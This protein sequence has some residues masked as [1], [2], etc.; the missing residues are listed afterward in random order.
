L[1]EV[2]V[3]VG[4]YSIGGCAKGSGMI[5]PDMATM[6]VFLTTDA[7]VEAAFLKQALRRPLTSLST[8]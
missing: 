5:H 2:A 6:L 1:K 8:C 4:D 3:K 7:P